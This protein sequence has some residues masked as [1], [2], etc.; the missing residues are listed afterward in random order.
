MATS[1]SSSNEVEIKFQIAD[2]NGLTAA[3]QKAGF[4]LVT[5]R[6]HEMNVLYDLPGDVLRG[7]GQLLRLREYGD[8][9]TLTFKDKGSTQSR[10]KSRPEI[11]TRLENGPAMG[12]ILES[13]GFTPSFSYE[14]YR[15][16]WTD[17]HGHVVIDETPVGNFGE[18]EGEPEWIDRVAARLGITEQQYITAS[19]TELFRDWK[20][21]TRSQARNMLFAETT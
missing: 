12:Q 1:S 14:K 10:H 9:W 17:Q 15:S 19:Y 18:I 8:R 21:K 3:L 4:Q 20:I 13:L 5:G 7:R 11:E 2:I 16:E 6:T